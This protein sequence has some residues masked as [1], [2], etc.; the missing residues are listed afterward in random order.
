MGRKIALILL[1]IFTVFSGA[2]Q[3]ALALTPN[4]SLEPV[5]LPIS[6]DELEQIVVNFHESSF[7]S[8]G[9]TAELTVRGSKLVS[10]KKSI[11]LSSAETLLGSL[12]DLYPLA[13]FVTLLKWTDDYPYEQI[14]LK[15]KDGRQVVAESSSQFP[16]GVPW[17]IRVWQGEAAK[18]ELLGSYALFH[19]DFHAGANELWKA[20]SGDDFPR[21]YGFDR[22]YG[23]LSGKNDTIDF[24]V[25]KPGESFSKYADRAQVSGLS[26]TALEPFTL[27]LKQNSELR[28]LFDTGFTLFDAAFDITVNLADRQPL[29]YSGMLALKAPTSPDVVVTTVKIELSEGSVRV[30]TPL[31]ARSAQEAITRRQGYAYLESLTGFLPGFVFLADLRSDAGLP[32]LTCARNPAYEQHDF[33]IEGLVM[34]LNAGRIALYHLPRQKA[35]TLVGGLERSTGQWDDSVI[36]DVLLHWFPQNLHNL[37]PA[38]LDS[39]NTAVGL[40]FRPEVTERKPQLIP[41][42]IHGFP[43][44]A[45]VHIANPQKD[46]DRSFASLEGE[47]IIPENGNDPLMVSCGHQRPDEEG[48]PY[49]L[50]SVRTPDPAAPR[51]NLEPLTASN[52][53]GWT[54]AFGLRSGA[55][56]MRNITFTSSKPGYLHVVWTTEQSS[57]EGVYYAEGW[58]D[59]TGWTQPQR[60]GDSSGNVQAVSN[61][62]GEVHLLWP[63]D[64]GSSGTMHVWRDAQGVWQEPEYWAGMG[65][66]SDVLLGKM[67]NLHLAWTQSDGLDQEFFY[68]AWNQHTGLSRPENISRRVGDIGNNQIVLREDGAG[69]IHAVW[70]HPLSGQQYIDPLSG[71]VFDQSGIFYAQRF[72]DG[73]WSVPEQIGAFAP[74]SYSLGFEFPANNEPVTVWQ[75]PQGIQASTRHKGRWARPILIQKVTPPATPAAS[76]PDRWGQATAE[77]RVIRESSEQ[78]TAVWRNLAKGIFVSRFTG[79]IWQ[80]PKNIVPAQGLHGL[81]AHSGQKGEIHTLYSDENNGLFYTKLDGKGKTVS[82]SLGLTY[83]GHGSEISQLAVDEAGFVVVMGSPYSQ[84]WKA[85]I[86]ALGSQLIPTPQP[87]PTQ[88][89]TPT[90]T[91]R[92]TPTIPATSAP[93]NTPAPTATPTP[94]LFG[95]LVTSNSETAGVLLL[96]ALISLLITFFYARRKKNDLL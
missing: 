73:G 74:F 26:E 88:T 16:K 42:L 52:Q 59:G 55:A 87:T 70:G 49:D 51:D 32:K 22:F 85:Y 68:S 34:G 50:A 15:L 20:L 35:W 62:K 90:S 27:V 1:V 31:T 40:T 60:L 39:L 92:A 2:N 37:I 86:P 43:D 5:S 67:G 82:T 80:S 11:P 72:R 53:D 89:A 24:Y 25:P 23:D 45:V 83:N 14:I 7:Q 18:S 28:E 69:Q 91:P 36:S 6:I 4:K 48:Q 21:N 17:N 64:T 12:H 61:A 54:P 38:D 81:S 44:Q 8:S 71:E 93:T 95:N 84:G 63:A 10:S 13:R 66:F 30:T 29:S 9:D 46:G 57:M 76:G 77:I 96:V 79:S 33:A 19:D 58:A 56:K 78:V 47:L 3:S 41:V 75:S 94:T 65:Y